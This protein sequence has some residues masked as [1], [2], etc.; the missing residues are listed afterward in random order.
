MEQVE[1]QT[2]VTAMWKFTNIAIP[3]VWRTNMYKWKGQS[4][5]FCLSFHNEHFIEILLFFILSNTYKEWRY[6]IFNSDTFSFPD[7]ITIQDDYLVCFLSDFD[8][9]EKL[10]SGK[11]K[12]K[13]L[14]IFNL[15]M[16]IVLHKIPLFTLQFQSNFKCIKDLYY[17]LYLLN[18]R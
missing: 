3:I 14:F 18:I 15:F 13:L 16:E 8:A 6:E 1:R 12:K 17:N 7:I 4:F 2:L 9:T 5:K 11:K 10:A